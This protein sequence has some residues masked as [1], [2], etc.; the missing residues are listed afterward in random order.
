M[1]LWDKD[2]AKELRRFEGHANA[3]IR[4]AFSPDGKQVVSGS[5]RYQSPDKVI[6]VWD[7]DTGKELRSFAAGEGEEVWCVA[8]S[9]DGT[10]A[11]TGSSAKSLHLWKL[12]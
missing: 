1:R 11:L 4:V 10:Q 9:P 12:K 3:V 7:A 2:S 8:F 6:R 5:S